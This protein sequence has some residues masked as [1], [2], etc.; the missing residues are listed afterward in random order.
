VAVPTGPLRLQAN[1][2]RNTLVIGAGLVLLVL[3]GIIFHDVNDTDPESADRQ[4]L[5]GFPSKTREVPS[6][7]PDAE[8]PDFH[9]G[10]KRYEALTLIGRGGMGRVYRAW[11]PRLKRRV[12]LKFIH[13][14]R[15]NAAERFIHE[16]QAQ[17]QVSHPHVCAVYETGVVDDK[18]YIAME[19]I[20]GPSLETVGEELDLRTKISVTHS[21]ALALH[22]AHRR[23]LIHRDV[24][25]SNIMLGSNCDGR[26]DVK[27]VDF[28]LSIPFLHETQSYD[29]D[30]HESPTID[31]PDRQWKIAGTP[32]YMA[33]EQALGLEERLDARTDVYGLGCTLY[34][35]L[36]GRPPLTAGTTMELLL[37]VMSEEPPSPRSLDPSIP[38]EVEA[39]VLRCLRK[40]ARDRYPTALA[41]AEDLEAFLENRVVSAYGGGILYRIGKRLR[42]SPVLSATAFSMVLATLLTTGLWIRT[43]WRSTSQ[44]NTAQQ[45]GHD[46]AELDAILW[47]TRSLP[48]HDTGPA[49]QLIRRRMQGFGTE[50]QRRG[51]VAAGPGNYALGVAHLHLGDAD[52]ALKFLERAIE[53]GFD[54]PD[55]NAAAGLAL[56]RIFQRSLAHAE[57]IADEEVRRQEMR[58]IEREYRDRALSFLGLASGSTLTPVAY[59]E[60][61]LALY[62][63]RFVDGLLSV[64]KSLDV[65]PWYYEAHLLEAD[66]RAGLADRADDLE[67]ALPE[68]DSALDAVEAALVIAPSDP[69]CHLQKAR[70]GYR[71]ALRIDNNARILSRE[72][73]EAVRIPAETVFI[74][75]SKNLEARLILVDLFALWANQHRVHSL[76]DPWPWIDAAKEEAGKATKLAPDRPDV[77]EAVGDIHRL[78]AK[79]AMEKGLDPEMDLEIAIN[80]LRRSTA[81]QPSYAR[82]NNLGVALRRLAAWKARH[83]EDPGPHLEEAEK[84]FL[85]ATRIDEANPQAWSNLAW[86]RLNRAQWTARH[87]EDPS[88]LLEGSIAT[89]GRA[90][91]CEDT[92][93]IHNNMGMALSALARHRIRAGEDARPDLERATVAFQTAIRL[94]PAYSFAYNNL[95]D[96]LIERASYE[97]DRGGRPDQLLE[98]ADTALREAA[99]RDGYASPWF[100]RGLLEKLRARLA[101][102]RRQDPRPQFRSAANSLEKGLDLRP[103]VAGALV[104]LGRVRFEIARAGP[105]INEFRLAGT[106]VDKALEQDSELAEA[107]SL[108]A[109]IAASVPTPP[110]L[111]TPRDPIAAAGKAL[112]INPA[113]PVVIKDCLLTC[114]E[115]RRRGRDDDNFA[116][117]LSRVLRLSSKA[118][119]KH[120][121]DSEL[122][123]LAGLLDNA[124]STGELQIPIAELLKSDPR[125]QTRYERYSGS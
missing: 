100:N 67:S 66:L 39:I 74:I 69:R 32:S 103:G 34:E 101:E 110:S 125:L 106:A 123:L 41:L 18:P 48:V 2:H 21:V 122:K 105:S 19:L 37:K 95:G 116:H 8:I 107:W 68:F 28:G 38:A 35:L 92:A 85:A 1:L 15:Q 64:R 121:E 78:A 93:V 56:G 70:I 55:V 60:G 76:G 14:D 33:P 12:A 16:A 104:E 65:A 120:G 62:E 91:E 57:G 45:F 23:G 40:D 7:I 87:G 94:M 24:K 97:L 61:M 11:D 10:W 5:T 114:L 43:E 54:T 108:A 25:P 4:T 75:D 73:I 9:D 90:L 113:E 20:E 6:E 84:T 112:D 13:S 51:T 29:T 96:I 80:S 26:L 102:D 89:F 53:S 36:V 3:R 49:R 82:H 88:E 31:T 86:V 71:R 47:K 22:A 98:A 46:L 59:V 63:E 52:T 58:R 109:L 77:L 99:K 83:G 124:E 50:V 17:A 118:L 72:E 27:V 30:N 117:L 79:A 119:E 44:A 111:T 81:I 42:K 115:I